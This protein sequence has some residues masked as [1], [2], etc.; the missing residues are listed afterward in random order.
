LNRDAWFETQYDNRGAVP[1]H[2]AI[3]EEREQWS[4]RVRLRRRCYLDVPY[5]SGEMHALDIFPSDGSSRAVVSFIHGG[6]WR[7]R[8]KTDFSFLAD[9]L[10]PEGYTLAV[11]NYALCPAATVEQAVRDMLLA[12]AWL[13]RNIGAYGGDPGRILVAGHSAGGQLAAMMAACDWADYAPGLPPDLVKGVL[14]ISGIYDLM[15]LR[16]TSMNRDLRLDENAARVA[17]PVTYHPRRR[18]PV[19]LAVGEAELTEF[20]RQCRLLGGRWSHCVREMR[21]LPGANHFTVLDALSARDGELVGVLAD[22][23]G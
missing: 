8:D 19:V 7:S 23:A 15:P 1:D 20:H 2:P 22:L 10:C 21:V 5:G 12:H 16:R 14:A 3:Y 11:P 17:S 6:Y 9:A 18:V 4:R 13:Y